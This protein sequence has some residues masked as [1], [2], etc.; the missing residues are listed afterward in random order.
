MVVC[1]SSPRNLD[2]V[3]PLFDV[4]KTHPVSK[5]SSKAEFLPDGESKP[6]S[7]TAATDGPFTDLEIQTRAKF[8]AFVQICHPQDYN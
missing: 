7:R 1:R 3:K 8:A 2:S 6:L 4:N 5:N